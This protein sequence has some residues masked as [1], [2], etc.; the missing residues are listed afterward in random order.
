SDDISLPGRFARQAALL[1]AE[2][3][4]TLAGCWVRI[5]GPSGEVL[6]ES[7]RPE[8]MSAPTEWKDHSSTGPLGHGSAMYRRKD[9]EAV[10]GYREAFYWAQ[11]VDLWLRLTEMGRVAF[12]PSVLYAYR[13]GGGC[14]S[15]RYVAQQAR[16]DRLAYA[17]ADVR[18]REGDESALL[19]E[20]RRIRPGA[21]G[22]SLGASTG[23]GD[24]FVGKC[25][26]DRRDRRAIGYLRRSLRRKPA[27]PRAWA[28]LLLASLLCRDEGET[29]TA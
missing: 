12:V 6:S 3:S 28:A 23:D 14:I 4:V 11:D 17:C 18:R 1:D 7:R 8:G 27:R 16:L 21:P 5:L 19:D 22:V 25:L 24:Y 2:A 13:L 20:A 26:L 15:L 10:G 9:Y 29:M